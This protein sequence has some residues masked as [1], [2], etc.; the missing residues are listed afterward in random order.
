[1]PL[2]TAGEAILAELKAASERQE[3]DCQA[4]RADRAKAAVVM[5]RPSRLPLR[6]AGLMTLVSFGGPVLIAAL[7]WGGS[8]SGWP[9]DR[10]VEWVGF[11]VVMVLFAACFIACLTIGWW[12]GHSPRIASKTDEPTDDR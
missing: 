2:E 6:P 12:H 11:G 1:M 5:N 10:P 4:R 3:A 9:P 8:R 7:L